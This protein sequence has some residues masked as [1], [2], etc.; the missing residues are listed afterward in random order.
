[1]PSH[2]ALRSE[3]LFA[4]RALEKPGSSDSQL[5]ELAIVSQDMSQAFVHETAVIDSN[6]ELGEGVRIWH[7][8]HV[9]EGAT[10][11]PGTSLGQNV[12]IG[13]GVRVGAGVKVQNNVSLYEGVEIEDEVFLGPSAVFTNVINPRAHVERKHESRRTRVGRGATVGANATILCGNQIG[14]Y[15][16]VAANATVTHD[17]PPFALVVGTPARQAG[18]V[19]ACGEKLGGKELDGQTQCAACGA[20]YRIAIGHCAPAAATE[21]TLLPEPVPMLDVQA[22]NASL[23]PAL[24]ASFE[25]VMTSGQ[26]ILGSEVEALERELCERFGYAHAIGVSS[27]TD[28]LLLALMALEVGPGDEVITSPFSFFATAGVVARLGARPVFV[29]ID[30]ASFNLDPRHLEMAITRKTKAIIPI[31]LFGQPA[32]MDALAAVAANHNLPVIEDAAQALGAT[33]RGRAVGTLGTFGCFSF[34]PSK[35]LGGFGDGGLLTTQRADLAE[36]ARIL[37][38]HGGQPKYYHR[39]VGGN[40]R[41]DALQAALLRA[42]LPLLGEY[43]EARRRNAAFYD[44]HFQAAD[45]GSLLKPP[46]RVEPGHVY[47][48]YVVRTPKRDALRAA[49]QAAGIASEVYYPLGLHLQQCFES[50]GGKVGDMPETE[51]ACAEVLA[52]P[53]APE[54][55]RLQLQRVVDTVVASLKV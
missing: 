46:A 48:Q 14:S 28:A 53:V 29:D 24:R 43:T 16:L 17:V 37:R 20:Q 18:W 41:L 3:P 8:V 35:N 38:S 12:F 40:F 50:L 54:L 27:G 51:R 26:F 45:L 9:S 47:N 49:L 7:L 6:V 39:L 33:C 2:G 55:S 42:K 5:D 13:K 1:V 32:D 25:R 21:P 22:Q 11:G 19:C 4:A 30:P 36:R 44:E 10:I 34:F 23:M 15:A 31:H 52:V